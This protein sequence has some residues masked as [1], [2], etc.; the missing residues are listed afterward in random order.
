MK[1]FDFKSLLLGVVLT[2]TIVVVMLLATSNR[3]PVAWEYKVVHG[4]LYVD[5]E[6]EISSATRDGWEVVGVGAE[7]QAG[8]FAVVR[9][10]KA[11]PLP[12]WKFWKK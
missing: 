5:Y 7:S 8:G 6:K 9:R 11:V 2:M 1:T 10:P 12:W 3:A 4:G